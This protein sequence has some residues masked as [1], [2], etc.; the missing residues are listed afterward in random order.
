MSERM[1][2][3]I[4]AATFTIIAHAAPLHAYDGVVE[5]KT[6]TLQSY[7]TVRGETIKNVKIG[8]E[9][10]GSLNAAKSNAI[11]ITHYFSGTSHA[12]G[13]YKTDDPAPV[14]GTR[15]SD[16]AS[17]S[18][19]TN[20]SSSP[21]T[22][23]SISTP[24]IQ[25]SSPPGQRQSILL[26]A[27]NTDARSRLSPSATSSTSRRRSSKASASPSF[28]LSWAL[29]WAPC[30]FTNGLPAILEWSAR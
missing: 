13:K 21:L 25:T 28:T 1:I 24:R 30:R 18:T 6:F 29:R 23:W 10:Y 27:S 9:S 2:A 15:S 14:T 11:L 22:R 3:L 4:A 17:R 26:P 19:P 12:A 5:K 20:I 7:V 16:R 8:W